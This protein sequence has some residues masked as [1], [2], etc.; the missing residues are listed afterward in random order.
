MLVPSVRFDHF[1]KNDGRDGFDEITLNLTYYL[2]ENVKIFLEYFN[3][4]DIPSGQETDS[5]VMLQV[6]A[7]F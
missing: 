6:E 5:R 7:G 2:H 4:L 1:E 3:Q